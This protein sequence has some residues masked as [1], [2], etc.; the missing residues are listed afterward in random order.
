[1]TICSV[2][3]SSHAALIAPKGVQEGEVGTPL[4]ER[5]GKGLTVLGLNNH[6]KLWRRKTRGIVAVEINPV[7]FRHSHPSRWTLTLRLLDAGE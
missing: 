4:D 3:P 1:M 5:R 6:V 7:L 2:S